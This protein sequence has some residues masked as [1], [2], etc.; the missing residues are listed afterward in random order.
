[1]FIIMKYNLSVSCCIY[2]TLS[3]LARGNMRDVVFNLHESKSFIDSQRRLK[4]RVKEPNRD[5]IKSWMNK[6]QRPV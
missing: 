4:A 6:N 1:M 3:R 5:S 2:W